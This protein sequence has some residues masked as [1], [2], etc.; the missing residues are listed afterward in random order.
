MKYHKSQYQL[1]TSMQP[2]YCDIVNV[3]DELTDISCMKRGILRFGRTVPVLSLD[4]NTQLPSGEVFPMDNPTQRGPGEHTPLA[5]TQD[6]RST[7]NAEAVSP[8]DC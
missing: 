2:H 5:G 8:S 4:P 3:Q 7:T 6:Q 1:L